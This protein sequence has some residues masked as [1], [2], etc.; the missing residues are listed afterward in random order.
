MPP[1]AFFHVKLPPKQQENVSLPT[2]DYKPCLAREKENATRVLFNLTRGISMLSELVLRQIGFR[3]QFYFAVNPTCAIDSCKSRWIC[4][5][6][7]TWW[8]TWRGWI[9][10]LWKEDVPEKSSMARYLTLEWYEAVVEQIKLL[11]SKSIYSHTNLSKI[12]M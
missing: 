11:S 8:R 6:Q 12:R 2:N 7:D 1:K 5:T 9:L 10:L 3:R 4:W